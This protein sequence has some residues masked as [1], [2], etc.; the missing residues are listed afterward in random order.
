[1]LLKKRVDDYRQMIGWGQACLLI[2]F[3][4]SALSTGFILDGWLLGVLGTQSA[5]DFFQGFAAGLAAVLFGLSIVLN[6]R[7]LKMYR[8]ES[9]RE[10]S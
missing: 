7:G 8:A 3:F 4:L 2:G 6:V 10:E 9:R 5:F 1:M